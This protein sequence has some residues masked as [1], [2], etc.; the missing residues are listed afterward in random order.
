MFD[1]G[2]WVTMFAGG[3]ASGVVFWGIAQPAEPTAT[4]KDGICYLTY[5]RPV[6][7][8][9]LAMILLSIL[10]IHTLLVADLSHQLLAVFATSVFSAGTLF[11]AYQVFLVR[12]AYDRTS[13]YFDSPFCK[14]QTVPWENLEYAGS[15]PFLR[16]NYLVV[17]GIGRIWS[18]GFLNGHDELGSFLQ[19]K[20]A[21]LL[22]PTEVA[23]T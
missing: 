18:L 11:I 19:G 23:G 14:D 21:T 9:A 1:P 13:L 15:V 2:G 7:I 20:A 6:K 8:L 10:A 17:T 16:A 22:R 12:F 3:I 4:R 5:G